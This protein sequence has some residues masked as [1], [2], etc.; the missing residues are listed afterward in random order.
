MI[1][2]ES[3]VA[4]TFGTYTL[5]LFDKGS[6]S[7]LVPILGVG[8]IILAF[9]V[10]LSGNRSV[11]MASMVMAVLKVGGILAFSIA[12]LWA[13]G[14]SFAA[15]SN[16]TSTVE[17]ST[18]GFVA[19]VAFS[20]LAYKGFTT[21]TNSGAEI[22][23]PHRNV[24]R[25][26]IWSILVCVVVYLLVAFAVSSTLSI[27][28][29]ITARDYSLAEA[30]GPVFGIYGVYFTVALAMV[31]TASGLLA[32]IFAVSRML[33][34]L[35]DMQLI[36]HRH[37]GMRGSIQS[38]MLVYTVVAAGFLTIFFDLGR[39][40]SLGVFFYLV[41]DIVIHWGIMRN[42]KTEIGASAT[43]MSIAIILDLIVLAV[44]SMVKI[45]SDPLIVVIAVISIFTVFLFEAWYLSQ[46]RP[47]PASDQ[48][49]H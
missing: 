42:L 15:T 9:L 22:T 40:A 20:I 27:T 33:T 34:M 7:V 19:S 16:A 24:G 17:F 41:M 32:S 43:I 14:F 6:D 38:H 35:T 8:L 13:S 25:A 3:L 46:S 48:H 26:I 44:F 29:I 36:P 12:A 31:A 39:I 4:R 23:N 18:T 45:A 47:A 5:R 21:I 49:K 2:N 37:F 10:N 11:G 1:I 28:Q 30:A